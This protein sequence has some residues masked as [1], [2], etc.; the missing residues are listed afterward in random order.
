MFVIEFSWTSFCALGD[1]PGLPP[2][3]GPLL[4]LP[5]E[6][7]RAPVLPLPLLLPQVCGPALTSDVTLLH[8]LGLGLVFFLLGGG[9]FFLRVGRF[10]SLCP[11]CFAKSAL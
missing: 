9:F 2:V 5:D 3:S 6:A 8:L 1:S 11:Q 10:I 7:V 4:F